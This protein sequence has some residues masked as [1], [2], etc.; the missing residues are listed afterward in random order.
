[1]WQK[2]YLILSKQ[3]DAGQANT[4]MIPEALTYFTKPPLVPSFL[5]PEPQII[6]AA[7]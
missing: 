1:M 5:K 4:E 7:T 2:I 6:D 3:N